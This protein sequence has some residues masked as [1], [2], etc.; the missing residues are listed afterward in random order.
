MAEPPTDDGW[1]SGLASGRL[2]P[3][4]AFA[5]A[6]IVV[7]GTL[8]GGVLAGNVTGLAFLDGHRVDLTAGLLTKDGTNRLSGLKFT[9]QGTELTGDVAQDDAGLLSGR[10][11]LKSTD[12]TRAAALLLTEATGTATAAVTLQPSGGKQSATIAANVQNVVVDK[13]TKI[14]TAKIDAKIDDVFGI[15]AIDGSIDGSRAFQVVA[16]AH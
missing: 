15:P 1:D 14:G 16:F 12:L 6:S 7:G 8:K 4:L 10:L 11:D 9:T 13:M 3:V 5:L 2:G